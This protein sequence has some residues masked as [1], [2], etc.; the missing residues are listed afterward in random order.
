[1]IAVRSLELVFLEMMLLVLLGPL[2]TGIILPAFINPRES[3]CG[4]T[5]LPRIARRIDRLARKTGKRG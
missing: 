3:R 4:Q 1:M 2:V 5:R